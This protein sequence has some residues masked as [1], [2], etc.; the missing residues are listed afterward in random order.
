MEDKEKLTNSEI[1]YIEFICEW[2]PKI[3]KE[4]QKEQ[5]DGYIYQSENRARFNRLRIE[6]NK[7][8]MKI[9]NKIYG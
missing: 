9:R 5:K 8:L 3:L 2:L 1:G 6:M 7:T 4:I